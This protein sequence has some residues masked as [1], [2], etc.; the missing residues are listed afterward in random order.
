MLR[1][2]PEMLEAALARRGTRINLVKIRRL[3]EERRRLRAEA[4]S[5]RSNQKALGKQIALLD[6]DSKQAIIAHA[7]ELS[8]HYRTTLAKAD[9]L[10]EVFIEMWIRVPN[11]AHPTA[12]DG[13]T[14]EDSHE[15]K[16][17]GVIPERDHPIRDHRELGAALGMIDIERAA[18]VSGSRF[19]FLTGPAVIIEFGLVRMALDLLGDKGFTPVVPPVLVREHALFGTGFFSDDDQ[20]VYALPRD[21]LYLAGTSEVALAAYHGDEILKE[22]DLP[23]RYAGFSSCF[24]REAGAAGKETAGIFRVH[25]FDKVEMFSFCH[26]DRSWDEHEFLLSLEE[27]IVQSLEIPYRVVNVA[28]GDL[29]ASAAKKYDIEAWI[30]SQERYREITSCS[31][32]TDFQSRRLRIRYKIGIRQP[33]GA[34]PQRD[35]CS[36]GTVA[37]RPDG[38]PSAGGR[39]LHSARSLAALCRVRPGPLMKASGLVKARAP[40]QIFTRIAHRYDLINRILAFGRDGSWRRSVVER[41]PPGRLLDL[42]AGTGAA[43]SLFGDR[44]VVALDPVAAMLELNQAPARVVAM[45]EAL[46]FADGSFDAV[47]SAFVF[48]N[49]D[50]VSRTLAEVARVLRPDGAAGIVDLGRPRHP[51][52]ASVHRA[53]SA[54]VV[55]LV[56]SLFG[57][58]AEYRYLHQS[59][60]QLAPPEQL[61]TD[62]PLRMDQLWRMGPLGFVYG[63]I[64]TRA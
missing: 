32:T 20:Q 51:L 62:A 59:L 22:E 29:G 24:R 38:K 39:I 60:D 64:L 33:A 55:P 10:D 8:T 41:L 16:R 44:R 30:P 54:T 36:G 12:A 11:L 52:A 50:S 37:D 31:N 45:G 15:F 43:G 35:G 21:D 47:F 4:E 34:Y 46:P 2:Q 13:Y 18:K 61:Y 27:E 19:G 6:G 1:Q 26:P 48:R 42:G 58:R 17:W 9:R 63:V 23:L 56:G 25:Q 3:D 28:A 14:E 7:A 5:I 57:A 40:D 49:L 53:A